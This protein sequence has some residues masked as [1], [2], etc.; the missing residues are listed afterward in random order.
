MTT[1]GHR[2]RLRGTD[3]EGMV[4]Q[5]GETS[6]QWAEIRPNWPFPSAPIEVRNE[7]LQRVRM[8][9]SRGDA[10]GLAEALF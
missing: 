9:D 4:T 2:Y 7:D 10:A 5:P 8:R 6:S 1:T 3:R